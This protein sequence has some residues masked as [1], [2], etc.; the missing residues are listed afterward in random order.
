MLN[1]KT[2]SALCG[3]TVLIFGTASLAS[4]AD[5][6]SLGSSFDTTT[7][8]SEITQHPDANG[9]VHGTGSVDKVDKYLQM[10]GGYSRASEINPGEDK[11]S[12][13]KMY[14]AAGRVMAPI[15]RHFSAYG[16][17]GLAIGA[18]YSANPGNETHDENTPYYGVGVSESV[19]KHTALGV[20][21]TTIPKNGQIPTSDA[22]MGGMTFTF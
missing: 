5:S 11:F 17:T 19:S 13:T 10:V 9:L 16:E 22:M 18:Q 2:L 7:G 15:T 8:Y 14:H 6:L 1:K 3:V 4:A 21:Y 12:R 20:D